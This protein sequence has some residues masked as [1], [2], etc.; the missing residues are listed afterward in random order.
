ME[1][2]YKDVYKARLGKAE[3]KVG[4]EVAPLPNKIGLEELGKLGPELEMIGLKA[5]RQG[6]VAVCTLAGGQGSRLGFEFP[7]G[8]Y[9]PGLLSGK[10]MFQFFADHL[11]ALTTFSR[12]GEPPER[13]VK[14][15]TPWAIMVNDQTLDLVR[16]FFKKHGNFGLAEES[17]LIFAQQTLPALDL[18]GR[19]IIDQP[20]HVFVSPNGNGGILSSIESTGVLARLTGAGVKYLHVLAVDNILARHADPKAIG[21]HIKNGH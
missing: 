12:G 4:D 1:S 6:Q 3:Q 20:G 14:L 7:K 13:P 21:Y 19:V 5:I 18:E 9:E 11:V 15:A 8:M 17:V 10:S 2:L 16:D